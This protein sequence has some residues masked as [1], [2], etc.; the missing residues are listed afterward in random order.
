MTKDSTQYP[1]HVLSDEEI[2]LFLQGDRKEVDRMILYSL[3]RLAAT[4]IPHVTRE[5]GVISKLEEVGGFDA[6]KVRAEFVDSLIERNNARTAMMRK[7]SESTATWALILFLGFL[8]T[9]VWHDIVAAVRT[10]LKVN[11]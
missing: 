8:A 6:I 2:E 5:D 10:A 9:A 7:V 3:N 4:V 1:P 11:S